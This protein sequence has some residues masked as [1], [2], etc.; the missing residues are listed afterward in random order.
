MSRAATAAKTLTIQLLIG[1]PLIVLSTTHTTT[2]TQTTPPSD[3][4]RMKTLTT[5]YECRAEG[6]AG[7]T[8]PAH[9][10]A[11]IDGTLQ[12]VT[13]DTGWKIA[14]HHAPG[15]VLAFCKR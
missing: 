15:T 4:A 10:L 2:T 9:A 14:Q 1:I 8:I 3:G 7:K 13:F 12:V 5:Q 6:F 11:Q